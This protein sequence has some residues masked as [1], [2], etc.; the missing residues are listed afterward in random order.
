MLFAGDP[1]PI[2][3]RVPRG[4]YLTDKLDFAPRVGVA[5][6]P[7]PRSGLLRHVFGEGKTSA[8]AGFGIFYAPTYGQSFS[9]FS[10][11]QPFNSYVEAFKGGDLEIGTFANP[12]G[13]AP[14]PFP[15][16]SGAPVFDRFSR[17]QIHTFDPAVR[18]AYSYQ[19]N[20]TLQRELPRSILLELSY[21]GSNSFRMD[22]ERDLDPLIVDPK[23]GIAKF[24]YS[25]FEGI[26]SQESSGRARY[27]SLQIRLSRRFRQGLSIDGFYVYSKAFD[28]ASGP[29]IVN[30][31]GFGGVFTDSRPSATDSSS[32][33]RSSFDRR[34]NVVATYVYSLPRIG[35]GGFAGRILNGWQ[36]G[37]VTQ[38]R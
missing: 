3:G 29:Q 2:L 37:G 22:R 18:N 7:S 14:N 25:N 10:G 32:W 24:P 9:D 15:V 19:Y 21:V 5:Y 11:A 31:F 28:N 34:H 23:T 13:S 6:S 38:L 27:D 30:P 8:R 26:L 4:A 1:D 16:S 33:A 12:F 36:I 35:L 17:F 20:L